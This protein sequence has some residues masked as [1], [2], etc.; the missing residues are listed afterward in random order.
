[1]CPLLFPE[2]SNHQMHEISQITSLLKTGCPGVWVGGIFA[3]P[4]SSEIEDKHSKI[5][6]HSLRECTLFFV[7]CARQALRQNK[8]SIGL[9][10]GEGFYTSIRELACECL[11]KTA[12]AFAQRIPPLVPRPFL[13]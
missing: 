12:P 6:L 11:F 5:A 10:S 1:V 13:C 3:T 4:I 8:G 9:P 2:N 7:H